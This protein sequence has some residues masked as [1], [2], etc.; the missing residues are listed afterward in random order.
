MY[1]GNIAKLGL[2]FKTFQ[3]FGVSLKDWKIMF[4]LNSVRSFKLN[5]SKIPY[6]LQDI[7]F[8]RLTP[9]LLYGPLR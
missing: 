4:L 5:F 9:R 8:D 2:R 1:I 3:Y 6:A 7:I